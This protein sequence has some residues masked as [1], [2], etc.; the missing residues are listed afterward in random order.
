M[1]E[2]PVADSYVADLIR[3]NAQL[4]LALSSRVVIEQ[5][6]GMLAER[7]QIS[8]DRAFELLRRSARSNRM[9]IHALAHRVVDERET[10]VE[11]EFERLRAVRRVG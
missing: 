3:K 4:E 11:I 9:R 2:Q 1:S 10:P 8:V 7:F 5:A 6:K